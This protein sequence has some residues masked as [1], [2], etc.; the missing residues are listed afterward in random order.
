MMKKA[1][2][3]RGKGGAQISAEEV[4]L[5]FNFSSK[6][7]KKKRTKSLTIFYLSTP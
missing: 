5:N 2:Q 6:R 1:E 3:E 4:S 7:I